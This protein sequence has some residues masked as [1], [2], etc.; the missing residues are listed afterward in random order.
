MDPE[1]IGK[2]FFQ[3][4]RGDDRSGIP[5]K[6]SDTDQEFDVTFDDYSGDGEEKEDEES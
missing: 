6:F 2:A 3:G 1:V 4:I 5:D